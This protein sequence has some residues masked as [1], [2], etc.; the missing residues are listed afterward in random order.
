MLLC[1][2]PD[3]KNIESIIE[4]EIPSNVL[5]TLEIWEKDKIEELLQMR[6]L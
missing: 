5:G 3:R 2:V 6:E 4:F 1:Y